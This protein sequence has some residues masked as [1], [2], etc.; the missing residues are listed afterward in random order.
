MNNLESKSN[1]FIIVIIL[2]LIQTFCWINTNTSIGGKMLALSLTG[3]SILLLIR[4]YLKGNSILFIVFLFMMT[5]PLILN[6]YYFFDIYFSFFNQCYEPD[7]VY[8]AA[9]LLLLFYTV[10]YFS[11]KIGSPKLNTSLQHRPNLIGYLVTMGFIIAIVFSRVTGDSILSSGS[12]SGVTSTRS[13]VP[14]EYALMFIPLAYIY[15]KNRFQLYAL[16]LFTLLF[17]LKY[18]LYGGRVALLE[19]FIVFFIL[20][21]QYEWGLKKSLIYTSILGILMLIYGVIRKDFSSAVFTAEELDLNS[22]NAGE[23]YYSSVRILYFLKYNILS[24]TDRAWSFILYIFSG[25]FYGLSLPPLSNLSVYLKDQYPSGGGGLAPIYFY[26]YLSYPGVLFLGYF[27]GKIFSKIT[28]FKRIMTKDVYT[29]MVVT[30]VPRW[31]AYY[32]VHLVKLCMYAS[33]AFLLLNLLDRYMSLTYKRPTNN[34]SDV[35]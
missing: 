34:L 7:L 32:P 4:S 31:F 5:Y 3:V 16:Y 30:M 28:E 19:V 8:F 6:A 9:Q 17:C 11:I 29:I 23:V 18:L 14:I 25:F 33:I 26:T 22:A 21:F 2:L 1:R 24:L 20:K 12:Y 35:Q 13:F 10:L 27:I 15:S